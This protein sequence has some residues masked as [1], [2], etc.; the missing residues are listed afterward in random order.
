MA[1]NRDRTG[2][3]WRSVGIA[4][5]VAALF[6]LAPLSCS[7]SDDASA[8]A[9]DG[10][11]EADVRRDATRLD[12]SDLDAGELDV[13][14][15]PTGTCSAT[16]LPPDGGTCDPV[17][18]CTEFVIYNFSNPGSMATLSG[19][20]YF[21]GASGAVGSCDLPDCPHID[22]LHYE[23][24][25]TAY[26]IAATSS[27]IFWNEDSR[28]I[29]TSDFSGATAHVATT[30]TSDIY[31]RSGAAIGST[32]YWPL[33]AGSIRACDVT[34]CAATDHEVVSAADADGLLSVATD[35]TSLFWTDGTSLARSDLDG[36]NVT[37]LASTGATALAVDRCGVYLAVGPNVFTCKVSDCAS[38]MT[39][40]ATMTDDMS[41]GWTS[42]GADGTNV[43]FIDRD[44]Q[45]NYV[46]P[47]P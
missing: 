35:G 32:Y 36:K 2:R 20:A 34:N 40:L 43:Y 22:L 9:G 30:E 24:G 39:V 3:A 14:T 8:P 27:G 31:P 1:M 10:G 29:W 12:A 19:T 6:A 11:E 7:G 17:A 26:G 25:H 4:S 46:I 45:R 47:E 42:L 38:T 23:A 5:S 16:A 18:G 44:L 21:T 15:T 28:D 33:A 37:P 41:P 13:G